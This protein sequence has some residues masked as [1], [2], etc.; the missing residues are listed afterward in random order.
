MQAVA[1][2]AVMLALFGLGGAEIILLLALVLIL[3]GARWIPDLNRGLGRG[4]FEFRRATKEVKDEIDEAASDAGRS[5]GGIY[6]KPAAE[7]LTP[8][9]QVAE[10][11]EPAALQKDLWPRRRWWIAGFVK[12]YRWLRRILRAISARRGV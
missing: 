10:L 9:N 1:A 12:L 4:I 8:E 11:Y 7:A 3:L 2:N 6:G 5:V